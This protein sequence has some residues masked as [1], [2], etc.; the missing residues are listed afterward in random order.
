MPRLTC[1][2][3]TIENWSE[4]HCIHPKGKR[5][6]ICSKELKCAHREMIRDG[7]PIAK[8]LLTFN[9]RTIDVDLVKACWSS[10]DCKQEKIYPECFIEKVKE[11]AKRYKKDFEILE[12][13]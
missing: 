13:E 9:I 1:Q 6:V 8:T 7:C 12:G 3:Q 11:W 4:F 10:Q 2:F 5:E